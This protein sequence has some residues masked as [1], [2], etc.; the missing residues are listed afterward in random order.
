MG[1]KLVKHVADPT[2]ASTD[3]DNPLVGFSIGMVTVAFPE[4]SVLLM[5]DAVAVSYLSDKSTAVSI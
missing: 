1:V 2:F 5:S 3:T 4:S